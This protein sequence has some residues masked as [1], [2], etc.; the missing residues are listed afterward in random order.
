MAAKKQTKNRR[1]SAL[2]PMALMVLAGAAVGYIGAEILLPRAREAASIGKY[3]L[4]VGWVLLALCA[5]LYLQTILHEAGH[6][7]FGLA[8]GYR[9]VSFRIGSLMWQKDGETLRFCRFTLAG[10]G[11]QCLM[12]PP[13]L[14]DG[15]MPYRLYNLGG[16]LMNLIVSALAAAAAMCSRELWMLR[17]FC[18]LLALIG[19]AAALTNGIPMRVGGIDNDGRNALM[20]GKDPAAMRALWVQLKVNEQQARGRSLG[21][22]PEEWFALPAEGMENPLVAAV[23]V[24]RESRLMEQHRF[25]EVTALID[26]LN[27]QETGILPMYENLLLCDRLTC[28]LLT[29]ED[30]ARLLK[31]WNRKEMRAFRK[32]AGTLLTVLRAEYTAALLVSRDETAAKRL[33]DKFEKQAKRYPMKA[34]VETER[35]LMALAAKAAGKP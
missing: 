6:L 21:Q 28:A 11:G 15:K 33:W 7:V 18:L 23:A 9:F 12:A 2:V 17:S 26:T 10:T 1:L 29:G 22:M 31:R 8:S 14:T 19:V 32:Q 30:P 13:D 5:A 25:D 4:E 35:G 3:L 24:L 27:A 20:L 16:V 34:D